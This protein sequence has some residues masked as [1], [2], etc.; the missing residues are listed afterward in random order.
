MKKI[1]FINSHPVQYF[2]P[3]YK[4]M[5]LQGLPT[6]CWYC[7]D[8]TLKGHK[9][10]QFNV[11]VKWDV[12]VLEG[13][14]YRFFKNYSWKPSLYNGFFGLFNPAMI[15]AL[16]REPKSV[17]V[18]HGWAYFTNILVLIFARLAGHTVCLRG[19]NPLNQ[20][21]L[22]SKRSNR[23]KKLWFRIFVFPF[24]HKFLFI[25]LQNKAFYLYYG[26]KE[27]SLVFVPYAVDNQRF[28]QFAGEWKLK[29]KELR[30]K[31][32]FPPEAQ[33]I[34][35]TAKFI[36]K[37]RPLDL[38]KAYASLQLENKCL[39]MVGDGELRSQMEQFITQN[40]LAGVYLP[41]FINQR[42][43]MAYYALADVFVL[44]SGEGET[45]GLSVNEAMNF[46]LP[47][48]VSDIAGCSNDLV[49]VGKNG[50]VFKTGDAEELSAKIKE[51]F[52]LD[53]HQSD[54]IIQ[55]YSFEFIR[56]SLRRISNDI[57]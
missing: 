1:I 7:S 19:E 2:A 10:R 31:L 13:Y 50:F 5:N 30:M 44:C 49:E 35:F 26:V 46:G 16:F 52:Q 53:G 17:V 27:E 20:E 32:G 3:L 40:G 9:D 11:D 15:T 38:L 21:R 51:A 37:K 47:V 22:K 12:P 6:A 23:V 18:V 42:E 41:G 45:W 54:E 28:Q 34:L 43:I 24:V 57:D 8:E 55:K 39:V 4:Y 36:Q 48:V 14:A 25:G 33:I 29:K 56:Q